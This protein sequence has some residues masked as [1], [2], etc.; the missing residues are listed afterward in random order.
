MKAK[1]SMRY[2]AD[3]DILTISFAQGKYSHSDMLSEDIFLEK[4]SKGQPLGVEILHA[5]KHMAKGKI[6]LKASKN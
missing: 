3:E 1:E 4:D 2:F 6:P 5:S